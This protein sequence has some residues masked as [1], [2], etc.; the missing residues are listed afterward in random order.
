MW[1]ILRSGNFH[2][3]T[4]APLIDAIEYILAASELDRYARYTLHEE[5]GKLLRI[6][7]AGQH[8]RKFNKYNP[9]IKSME[10]KA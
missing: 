6:F 3:L 9:R 1:L 5:N 2:A 8:V 4:G 10:A 7:K